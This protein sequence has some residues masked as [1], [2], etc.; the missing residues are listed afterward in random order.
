MIASPIVRE[1][2]P[3]N[4]TRTRNREVREHLGPLTGGARRLVRGGGAVGPAA[5]VSNNLTRDHRRITPHAQRD[6]LV[7]Q[8]L[9]QAT[10]YGGHPVPPKSRDQ[11]LAVGRT[12]LAAKA[13]LVLGRSQA[14]T[15][16]R[17]DPVI[18]GRNVVSDART[19]VL[20]LAWAAAD[21]VTVTVVLLL[22]L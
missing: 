16:G 22:V 14:G 5:A 11:L 1:S 3:V 12:L 17:G 18:T 6:L 20:L 7:L 8:A 10:G 21:F 2:R 19:E 4:G 13:V 9:G 15:A